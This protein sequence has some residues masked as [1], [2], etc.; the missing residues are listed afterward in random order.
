[1][2]KEQFTAGVLEAERGLYH[3]AKSILGNDEDCADAIQE[4]I[5]RAFSAREKLRNEQYF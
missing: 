2:N 1:M 5:L 3:V 4:A